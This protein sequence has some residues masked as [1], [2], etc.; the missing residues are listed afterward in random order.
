VNGLGKDFRLGIV[1]L[2]FLLILLVLLLNQMEP[3]SFG[4]EKLSQD[5]EC[6]MGRGR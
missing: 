1:A 5:A 6:S 3:G 2:G 4:S